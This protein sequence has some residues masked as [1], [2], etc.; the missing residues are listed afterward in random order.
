MQMIYAS[1]VNRVH[2]FE[3]IHIELPPHRCSNQNKQKEK[4]DKNDQKPIHAQ[5]MCF[6]ITDK[7]HSF[8]MFIN[9]KS[10]V[11]KFIAD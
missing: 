1:I 7:K 10:I 9:L 5:N 6:R 3:Y 4:A 11:I 8:F 2:K